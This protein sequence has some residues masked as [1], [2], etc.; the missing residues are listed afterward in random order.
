MGNGPSPLDL[1]SGVASARVEELATQ[2][3]RAGPSSNTAPLTQTR[4]SSS[5]RSTASSPSSPP[6]P[7]GH[8]STAHSV[9][10]ARLARDSITT[11]SAPYRLNQINGPA[12]QPSASS[13]RLVR[14]PPVSALIPSLPAPQVPQYSHSARHL[15]PPPRPAPPPSHF[16]HPPRP[17]H[18]PQLVFEPSR[19][20][21]QV[22]P[23]PPPRPREPVS[24]HQGRRMEYERSYPAETTSMSFV[25]LN[26]GQ[27]ALGTDAPAPRAAAKDVNGP[28]TDLQASSMASPRLDAQRTPRQSPRPVEPAPD[29]SPARSQSSTP[30]PVVNKATSAGKGP[31]TAASDST[32][33]GEKDPV[34]SCT[35]WEDERCVVTQVLVKGHVVAR[36]SDLN[37]VNCTKLLN[38][39]P[40]L[41]RGKRDMYL[42]NEGDRIVFRRG[43]LHLKG[44]WLPLSAAA[45]LAKNFDL[46][47]CLYPLFEPD[48]LQFLFR[49]VNRERTGQLIQ[50]ARGREA[51]ISK[52]DVSSGLSEEDREKLSTRGAALEKMLCELEEGLIATAPKEEM[53]QPSPLPSPLPSDLQ[54]REPDK[55]SWA[56][57]EVDE[58]QRPAKMRRTASSG[59]PPPPG[60]S[61]QRLAAAFEDRFQADRQQ[62]AYV[63]YQPAP[64][65]HL[66]L[67]TAS[68]YPPSYMTYPI[69]PHHAR[70]SPAEP[71]SA[72]PRRPSMDVGYTRD[73]RAP[74]AWYDNPTP[75]P[76]HD[77][78]EYF[79]STSGPTMR[80]LSAV[81][82][83]LDVVRE[84][85][86]V[87]GWQ[88]DGTL[89][90]SRPPQAGGDVLRRLSVGSDAS[91]ASPL[92]FEPPYPMQLRDPYGRSLSL[93][94][95]SDTFAPFYGHQD[96]YTAQPN[97]VYRPEPM[98]SPND[99]L[100]FGQIHQAL[101]SPPVQPSR[102]GAARLSIDSA[103]EAV[104]PNYGLGSTS[105]VAPH[106]VGLMRTN[107]A[108][109]YTNW[110]P[111][112]FDASDWADAW[113]RQDA[114]EV[115][116]YDT[117]A[118]ANEP[119]RTAQ[120][121]FPNFPDDAYASTSF[122]D[123]P[124]AASGSASR[125]PHAAASP[126][127]EVPPYLDGAFGG[128]PMSPSA[129]R[130]SLC[131]VVGVDGWLALGLGLP[132]CVKVEPD[133]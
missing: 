15:A 58:S 62:L 78:S 67:Y 46:Y 25:G 72:V 74:V 133:E 83:G 14:L 112:A 56:T 18:P 92:T 1:L 37:F 2:Y 31:S 44:V 27:H 65:P 11:L 102:L 80:R 132:A 99:E 32:S 51:L 60:P 104:F 54:P 45:R 123:T 110:L 40:G 49:P 70:A 6:R 91:M 101:Y 114:G 69:Q 103:A 95:S 85:E 82:G 71:L 117:S 21:R 5:L 107:G 35:L 30:A 17:R 100:D 4:P 16:A 81:E 86:E 116:G 22:D 125:Y 59:P 131:G 19:G 115:G 126:G 42:K 9:D 7:A 64:R 84:N 29:P 108:E 48:I 96:I 111:K 3:R 93:P 73:Y 34:V 66:P 53:V 68:G 10:R 41:T 97:V 113:A 124:F 121:T 23:P 89:A 33:D 47:E 8:L 13:A 76:A 38:M 24:Q 75:P 50:A 98:A 20:F 26:G 43:A 118:A 57:R 63:P 77:M 106:S 52:P 109:S 39:V 90:E 94:A 120:S 105:L 79:S 128:Q 28:A 87:Q 130:D 12:P 119:P 88:A 36:R 122:A 127:S 55:R 129:R 61:T